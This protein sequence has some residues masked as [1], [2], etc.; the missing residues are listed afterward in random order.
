MANKLSLMI[1]I[2]FAVHFLAGCGSSKHMKSL[3][4]L[5]ADF[6]YSVAQ[7]PE[8]PFTILL[9]E[10]ESSRL[11]DNQ[12]IVVRA[13]DYIVQID[14]KAEWVV[15]PG[16]ALTDIMEA[17]LKK[18]VQCRSIRRRY[19][20]SRPDFAVGGTIIAVEDDKR[21]SKRVVRFQTIYQLIKTADDE[22]V[23]EKSYSLERQLPA[24]ADYAVFAAVLNKLMNESAE[25]F[26][27]EVSLIISANRDAKN[28]SKD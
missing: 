9:R 13:K 1:L 22:V 2:V 17:A 24:N 25:S 23:V 10:I 27:A 12:N 14:K 28:N 19:S 4:A 5:R 20:D 6:P 3:I 18:G 16:V 8:Y 15:R 11:A 21:N 26:A 7:S